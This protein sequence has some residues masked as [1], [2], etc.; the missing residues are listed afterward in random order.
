MPITSRR[1]RWSRPASTF[2]CG[3]RAGFAN[4]K[5]ALV[6]IRQLSREAGFEIP[7]MVSGTIQPNGT[8]LAGQT[9]DA[10]YVSVAHADLLSFGLELR[11][12]PGIHDRPYPH[13][14]TRCLAT[15]ISC[16]PNAGLPDPDG[17]ISGNAASRSRGNSRSS[18]TM[19]GSILW[20]A[21]AE[22]RRRICR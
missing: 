19:A 6:A 1:K 15:R 22:P 21:A 14:S 8:M 2:F 3:N 16:Y 7:V 4:V 10:F 9:A 5:A 20:A 17:Q 11:H 13:A 18:P 12:R